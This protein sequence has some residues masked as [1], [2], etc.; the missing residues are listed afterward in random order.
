MFSRWHNNF[1]IFS[2]E[3]QTLRHI[4]TSFS[5]DIEKNPLKIKQAFKTV[6]DVQDIIQLY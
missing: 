6:K 3:N 4:L 1:I 2:P 5:G